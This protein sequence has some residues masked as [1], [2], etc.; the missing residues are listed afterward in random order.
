MGLVVLWTKGEET[1]NLMGLFESRVRWAGLK[2]FQE[3][4]IRQ[5]D[6]LKETK[7]SVVMRMI[8]RLGKVW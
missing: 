3:Q 5:R 6:D 8:E 7:R 1:K 4:I 2:I